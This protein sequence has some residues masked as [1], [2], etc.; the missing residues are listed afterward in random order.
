MII[1]WVAWMT[2]THCTNGEPTD[3]LTRASAWIAANRVAHNIVAVF[4]TGDLVTTGTSTV[5]WDKVTASGFPVA[6]I[7]NICLPGNH[8]GD[9]GNQRVYTNYEA[10][11]PVTGM[12]GYVG[13]YSAPS[14][15]NTY[16]LINIGG[17]QWLVV[18]LEFNPSDAMVAW[19]DGVFA[20]Y[21]NTPAILLTHA[22][23]HQS[24]TLADAT[25]PPAYFY[26]GFTG[27]DNYG[28]QLWAKS[29]LARGNVAMVLSGHDIVNVKAYLGTTRASGAMFPTCHHV[30]RNYQSYRS[31]TSGNPMIQLIG[32]DYL[33]NR[34]HFRCFSPPLLSD[35]YLAP[36]CMSVPLVG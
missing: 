13:S 18:A 29:L 20:A 36:T 33:N 10:R 19:A 3:C 34:L 21:P 14:A 35:M 6:G 15:R 25:N 32:F 4:H 31:E 28:V 8:D 23:L 7:P 16:H 26:T 2:D 12:S 9:Q 1:P 27:G 11:L 5:E 30:L 17:A 22:S 24:G